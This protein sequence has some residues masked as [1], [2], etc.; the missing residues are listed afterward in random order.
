M[1]EDLPGIS[2]ENKQTNDLIK[3]TGDLKDA[4]F[5]RSQ[6]EM[7]TPAN[8]SIANN[9]LD[10]GDTISYN[11][12]N[13]KFRGP[14][15]V[16]GVD[17]L[18]AGCSFTYG[19]GVPLDGTWPDLLS[20]SS[21][22]S[23]ANVSMPGASIE[24]IIDS[25]FRYI[26]TFGKPK[27]GIVALFPDIT[28][29]QTVVD[30]VMSRSSS[31]SRLDFLPRYEDETGEK[32]LI[33]IYDNSFDAS[34]Y[35]KKPYPVEETVCMEEVIRRNISKIRD[36]ERYCA[37]ADIK[38]VWCSWSD[39]TVELVRQLQESDTIFNNFEELND[40]LSM[41]ESHFYELTDPE[42][43]VDHKLDHWGGDPARYGCSDE[44]RYS[45]NCICFTE[46]HFE[47]ADAY[48]G[49]FHMGLDRLV[50]PDNPHY[51]VH[52]HIHMADSFYDKM[53]RIGFYGL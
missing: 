10:L 43:I 16:A 4:I 26:D 17:L 51:G 25:I 28:R 13:Y 35:L 22:K 42:K 27:S 12:N 52:R 19:V 46:C 48:P 44:K 40:A 34:S 31:T 29:T 20:K 41:W 8:K 32:S 11:L 21:G 6:L 47:L 5:S 49:S 23:Y 1:L 3:I 36:L 39:I 14:N 50:N 18:L 37:A 2:I 24:W 15:Y 38:F 7:P 9:L 45:G 30:G 33:S 53:K